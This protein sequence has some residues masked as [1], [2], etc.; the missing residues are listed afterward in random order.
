[1]CSSEESVNTE[2]HHISM[3]SSHYEEEYEIVDIKRKGKAQKTDN[4]H[5]QK[6]QCQIFL[7]SS[8]ATAGRQTKN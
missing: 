8:L 5:N 4:H 3:V 6:R 2:N 7:A 1:M